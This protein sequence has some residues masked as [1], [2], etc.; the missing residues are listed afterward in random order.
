LKQF[1]VQLGNN[2]LNYLEAKVAGMLV[3]TTGFVRKTEQ[4]LFL[5]SYQ[6]VD[7]GFRYSSERLAGAQS[8][9][10]QFVCAFPCLLNHLSA[11]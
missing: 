4:E 10:Q 7:F 2:E 6:L 9:L 1:A 8:Y 11:S 3:D 5:L